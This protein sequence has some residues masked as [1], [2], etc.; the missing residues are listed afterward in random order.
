MSAAPATTDLRA[1]FD[2]A[3]GVDI[4]AVAGVRLFRAGRRW[5]GPCPLCGASAG[6]KADGAFSVDKQGGLFWCHA[7]NEHGDVIA[8]EQ[9]L[10]GGTAREAAERLSGG[11]LV[12][13]RPAVPQAR[14]AKPVQ[15]GTQLSGRLWDQALPPPHHDGP[16][17][18]HPLRR[19]LRSRG[20][21]GPSMDSALMRLRYL[22]RAY[23]GPDPFDE[24]IYL[25]A[26]VAQVVTEAGPTG[27]VHLTYLDPLRGYAKTQLRPGK[28][29][30]GP[31]NDGDGRPG[32]VWL[33]RP[34]DARV[35]VVAEGIETA[36]A[37]AKLQA[38]ACHVLA[39]LSLNRLQGGWL[40]DRWG[41]KN[42]DQVAGDPDQPAVT[43]DVAE[44]GIDEVLIAIDRD[45]SPIEVPVRG[46]TGRTVK[47]AIDGEKRAAICAALAV[48]AWR[49]R[50]GEGVAVRA[51][52]PP[53]GLDFNDAL[54]QKLTLG[55]VD[56]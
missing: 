49:A 14:P 34:R 17:G 3:R 48:A 44:A 7:C 6:K 18:L 55:G 21:G 19:Y 31:Q 28:K 41:R 52:A 39:A 27:G 56:V 53:P 37:A 8:L 4:E 30:F 13:F 10:R 23:Y 45:M 22:P 36:L 38:G 2:S 15:G 5:R 47:R 46:P 29:M 24:P 43:W 11:S 40:A 50:L 12:A 42:P 25:P 1:L 26:M 20:L 16:A 32:G 54:Q 33:A 9:A 51:I 35:L